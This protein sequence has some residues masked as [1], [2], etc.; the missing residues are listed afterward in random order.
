MAICAVSASRISPIITTSGSCRK[1]ARSARAKVSSMRG[2][3]CVCPTPGKSYSMGSSTVMM[4]LCAASSRARLAYSV[5]VLPLPVGPVTKMMPCGWCMSCSKRCS[6][7]PCMPTASSVRRL[8]DLSSRR[9][10]ARSPCAPGRVDTRTS[11][12]RVPS[13]RLMRPSCGRRFSAMSSSAMIFRRLMSAA[14]S[15][16]LGCTTSRSV[17]STRKRTLEWRS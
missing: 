12:A 5:V 2:F 8:S 9:S 10:T 11:M 6:T 16:R 14:C 3:T 1:M 17:P 15:A 13:R 4:L 7:P